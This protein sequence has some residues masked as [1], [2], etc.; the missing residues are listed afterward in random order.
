[1]SIIFEPSLLPTYFVAS[2]SAIARN[3]KGVARKNRTSTDERVDDAEIK[4]VTPTT[5][6]L[7]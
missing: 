7:A 2:I 3:A 6:V 4:P 1:M 5:T